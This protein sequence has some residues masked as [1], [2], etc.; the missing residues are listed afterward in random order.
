MGKK[1]KYGLFIFLFLCFAFPAMQQFFHIFKEK[2]LEGAYN[3]PKDS[4]FTWSSWTSGKFQ[5]AFNESTNY[6]I[7]FRTDFVRTRNQIDFTLFDKTHVRD[8]VKG[9]NG[10]LFRYTHYYVTGGNWRG[11]DSLRNDILTLKTIQDSLKV[12]GKYLLYVI[13]PKK[14]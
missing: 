3:V 10:H 5:E 6:R 1:G 7:G 8:V 9:K 13:A 14:L 12:K 4:S 11:E 2:P